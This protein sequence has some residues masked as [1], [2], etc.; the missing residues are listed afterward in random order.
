MNAHITI[1]DCELYIE[2]HRIFEPE[3]NYDEWEVT[4][5]YQ[6]GEEVIFEDMAEE[7][8]ELILEELRNGTL[9]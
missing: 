5:V 4:E 3:N 2:A 8:R 1:N 9:I 6:D 7:E